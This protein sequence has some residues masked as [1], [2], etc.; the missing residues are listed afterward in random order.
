MIRSQKLNPFNTVAAGKRAT[1]DL[2]MG[3]TLHRI[4]LEIGDDGTSS[5]GLGNDIPQIIDN[6]TDDIILKV[7]GRP[8]RTHTGRELDEVINGVNGR[9]GSND[10]RAIAMG[11][12]GDSG[13]RVF[14]SLYL[15]EV[16]RKSNSQVS[17]GAWNLGGVDSEGVAVTTA[18][19]EVKMK[20]GLTNPVLS[21]TMDYEP[22][23]GDFGMITKVL[24][25]DVGV[26]GLSQTY[27]N[28]DRLDLVHA[29]HFLPTSGGQ[30]VNELKVTVGGVEVHDLLT[31]VENQVKLIGRELNPD[32][33][34]VPR[35]DWIVDYDDPIGS[36]LPLS[37]KDKSGNKFQVGTLKVQANFNAASSGNM[38]IITVRSGPLD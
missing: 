32:T 34:A 14:L 24:R 6:L 12:P 1:N 30:F 5:A 36:G 7:N 28:L 18:Q 2:T 3:L 27:T 26:G 29:M 22:L 8:Q 19:L 35:Y 38:R 17:M 23:R 16:W 20:D 21:G 11:V 15:A 10:Y 37:G 33:S 25:N 4:C 13:F 9:I 31:N